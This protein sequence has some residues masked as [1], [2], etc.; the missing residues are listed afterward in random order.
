ME[1]ANRDNSRHAERKT[2]RLPSSQITVVMN[3]LERR[4]TAALA[5][6]YACRMLGLFMLLPVL[7]VAGAGYAHATPLLIGAALGIYGLT[8][9]LLQIPFGLASDRLGRKPVI[10]F[11]LALFVVGSLVAATTTDMRWLIL[12]RALQGSGA[13]AATIMALL[14]DLTS[15]EQRTKAMAVVGVSIGASYMVALVL[16]PVVAGWVGLQG[17]FLAIAVMGGVALLLLWLRVPTPSIHRPQRDALPA[18]GQLAAAIRQR[19]TWRLHLSVFALHALMTASFLVVPGLLVSVVGIA[20]ERHWWFYLPVLVVSVVLMI[21]LLVAAERHQRL[22][23]VFIGCVLSL[24]GVQLVLALFADVAAALVAALLIFFTAFNAME[25]LLPSVI[26]RAAPLAGKG[27]TLGVFST[28]QFLG[29]FVGGFGGGFLLAR[30]GVTGVLLAGTAVAL[31]WLVAI[32]PLQAPP[33]LLTRSVDLG[34]IGPDRAAALSAEL[35]DLPGVA[36]VLVLAEEGVAYLRVERENYD[37]ERVR[38]TLLTVG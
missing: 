33:R 38:R 23:A 16:G 6:I 3:P 11:G 9:A 1:P 7:A 32:F 8:Q 26:S 15:D 21:P 35:M 14:A 36:E 4:A 19:N 31:V 10:A 12:G 17:L 24:G 37:P 30:F 28:A 5:A 2:L 27:A 34:N 13:V 20:I 22:R 25:A 18:G 29:A